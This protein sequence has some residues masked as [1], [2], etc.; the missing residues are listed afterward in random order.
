MVE[1]CELSVSSVNL[2]II[3]TFYAFDKLSKTT[4]LCIRP[5]YWQYVVYTPVT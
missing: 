3:G 4:V 1:A 2:W 5:I